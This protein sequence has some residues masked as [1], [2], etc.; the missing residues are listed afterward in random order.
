MENG[1]CLEEFY[2]QLMAAIDE[3]IEAGG[4]RSLVENFIQE[5]AKDYYSRY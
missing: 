5:S 2:D 4:N 3:F 1:L